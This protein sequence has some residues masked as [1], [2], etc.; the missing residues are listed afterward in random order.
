[1]NDVHVDVDV[2]VDRRSIVPLLTLVC[3][4]NVFVF[5]HPFAFILHTLV[6]HIERVHDPNNL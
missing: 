2:R 5:Q 3:K 1:M 4:M 6:E